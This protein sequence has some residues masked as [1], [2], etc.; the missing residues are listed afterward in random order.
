VVAL[1]TQVA[2]YPP[3]RLRLTKEMFDANATVGDKNAFLKTEVDAF[4]TMIR[5][6]KAAAT[7]G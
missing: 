1:S 4:V 3:L 6:R 5:A 7:A 2:G